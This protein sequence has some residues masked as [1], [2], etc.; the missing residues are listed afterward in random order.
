MIDARGCLR[1]CKVLFEGFTESLAMV[2]TRRGVGDKED[3][4]HE[5]LRLRMK[6]PWWFCG[7]LVA[8]AG[9]GRMGWVKGRPGCGGPVG[10]STRLPKARGVSKGGDRDK[11]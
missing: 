11:R 1:A 6:D 9:T 2:A 7:T 3:I 8:S 10:A 4:I 5:E